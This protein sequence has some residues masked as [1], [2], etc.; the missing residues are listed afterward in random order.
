MWK[1]PNNKK[2]VNNRSL[3]P[4]NTYTHAAIA[5]IDFFNLPATPPG[6]SLKY[7]DWPASCHWDW[8]PKCNCF[9]KSLAKCLLVK[10]INSTTE[11]NFFFFSVFKH[12]NPSPWEYIKKMHFETPKNV[13]ESRFVFTEQVTSRPPHLRM[14]QLW[15]PDLTVLTFPSFLKGHI[16][17][18]ST[19]KLTAS[20]LKTM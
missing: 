12:K 11:E 10:H 6:F 4:K 5:I 2:E 16:H 18:S 1:S 3:P 13:V 8:R 14:Q 17:L 7:L 15:P 20:G 9:W 19:A